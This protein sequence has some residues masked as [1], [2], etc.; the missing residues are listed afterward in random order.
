LLSDYISDLFADLSIVCE[1]LRQLE[2]FQPWANNYENQLVD[3]KEGIMKEFEMKTAISAAALKALKEPSALA[4]LGDPSDKKFDY[5]VDRR[6]NKE[7]TEAMILAE[8]NLNA[9]WG[10]VDLLLKKHADGL[11]GSSTA[12]LL[13]SERNLRRTAPWIEP[14]KSNTSNTAPDDLVQPLSR[15]YFGLGT[16]AS[17]AE[18]YKPIQTKIK[19]KTRGEPSSTSTSAEPVTDDE[20]APK[21]KQTFDA[22]ARALKVF[23]HLFYT[24]SLTATPGEV[25]WKDFL[26]AMAST[27]FK[28]EKLSGA[29]WQF[30]PTKL[31]VERGI[32]IHEPHPSSKIEFRKL[33]RYGRRLARAYGWEGDM[34]KLKEKDG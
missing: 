14:T 5:P 1:C 15:L 31:D 9:F 23:K 24:P 8:S 16:S 27:G 4:R 3:K 12:R 17:T 6:R 32:Q 34:F 2:L 26:H 22:D 21:V 20:S 10:E 13:A 25:P 29:I 11:K 28:I 7:N 19:V 18:K 33:R 30:T